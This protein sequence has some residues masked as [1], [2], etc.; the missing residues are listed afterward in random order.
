MKKIQSLKHPA[1]NKLLKKN[2]FVNMCIVVLTCL[3]NISSALD[4]RSFIAW[5]KSGFVDGLA[6]I[7]IT[8]FLSLFLYPPALVNTTL[9]TELRPPA[10]SAC[11]VPWYKMRLILLRMSTTPKKS[12]K[13]K[14]T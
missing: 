11:T 6:A 13:S 14:A 10:K 9:A 3:P 2:D 4:C 5:L 1:E 12:F 7:T 8:T